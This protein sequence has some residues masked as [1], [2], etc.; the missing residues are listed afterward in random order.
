M[1]RREKTLERVSRKG[2]VG[3]S[4]LV[5]CAALL[6][7]TTGVAAA[8]RGP[9]TVSEVVK[10]YR[11]KVERRLEPRF[12]Y[13]GVEWPPKGRV[14]LLVVKETRRMEVWA[15]Q[16]DEWR[17]VR[18]YR[19][20]GMSGKL[21]PKLKEGDRQVPEGSY[22]IV[23]LNPNSGYHLSLKINYPNAFDRTQAKEDGRTALGGNIYIH[24]WSVSRG[25]LAV[26]NNAAEELFVLASLVGK[27]KMSVLI[28]PRDF[29][30]HQV[31]PPADGEPPW[32]HKLNEEIA[33]GMQPYS[34]EQK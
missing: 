11:D 23:R 28:T 8:K 13:A 15:E 2:R 14:T 27:E 26:G 6:L 9:L 20:K 24:G 30:I 32:R 22:Q 7:L 19:I 10:K 3:M 34:L 4:L 25:C 18:E 16:D 1:I 21:G 33:A 17:L 5:C 12:R 29:R 31:P